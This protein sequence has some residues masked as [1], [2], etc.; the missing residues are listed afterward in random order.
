[1][2]DFENWVKYFSEELV[3]PITNSKDSTANLRY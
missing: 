3:V 1:M 2:P